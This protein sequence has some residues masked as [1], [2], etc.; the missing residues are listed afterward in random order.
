MQELLAAAAAALNAP[1]EMVERSARARAQVEGASV[2][3]VLRAW[4]GGGEIVATGGGEAP[5]AA[6]PAAGAPAETAPAEP[7]GPQVEIVGDA[8]EVEERPAAVLEEPEEEREE[9]VVAGGIPNWLVALFVI[10]P[11]FAIMY[12]L[13]LPNGPN[14]GDAGKLAVDPVTG[15]AVNC[16]GSEYGLDVIDFFAVGEATYSSCLACHGAGGGGAGNFPAFTGGALLATFPSGQCEAH[17][18]WVRLGSA[19]W[20]EPTYGAT[21]KP[22]GGSGA[23]MPGFGNLTETDLRSVVLYERV[24]FGG[25]DLATAEAD[26]GL[27]GGDGETAALGG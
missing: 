22:V 24:A 20:P 25:E 7:A 2:E 5:A 18:D 11:A 6:A 27:T 8:G 14:C 17:V 16:D 15:E 10:I 23:L 3:D 21:N 1:A 19:G 26:C 13:F 12:A 9:L 4:A